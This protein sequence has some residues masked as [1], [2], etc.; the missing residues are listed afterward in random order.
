[1]KTPRPPAP[2][3]AAMV[4]TPMQIAVATRIP[5]SKTGAASGNCTCQSTCRGVIPMPRADSI[6]A[7]STSAIPVHVFRKIG[8]SAYSES[9]T[10]A[11]LAPTPPIHGTGIRKPNSARLGIV[12]TTLAAPITQRCSRCGEPTRRPG[13]IQ[14]RAQSPSTRRPG[15]C[16]RGTV[17]IPRRGSAKEIVPVHCAPSCAPPNSSDAAN[18]WTSGSRALRNSAGARPQPAVPVRAARSACPGTAPLAR[19]A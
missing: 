11:V 16:A 13:A 15:Q 4:V 7:G 10:M 8:N 12:C 5:A 19:H 9:A 14:S 18:A 17:R 2:I 3:A 1:M 6:T